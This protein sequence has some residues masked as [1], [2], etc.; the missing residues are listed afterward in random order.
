MRTKAG[1]VVRGLVTM[2]MGGRRTLRQGW[3]ACAAGLGLAIGLWGIPVAG[4]LAQT[5]SVGLAP[6]AAG[7]TGPSSVAGTVSASRAL[8]DPST[9]ESTPAAAELRELSAKLSAALS[10]GDAAGV[11]QLFVEDGELIDE[12]GVMHRGR[13]EIQ[14][15][16]AAFAAKFPGAQ[17]VVEPESLRA[18]GPIMIEDGTRII[19]AADGSVAVIR[20]TAVLV[21]AADGWR[22]ASV[23]DFPDEFPVSPGEQLQ[24]LDWLIG[25]WVNEGVD[26]RVAIKYQWSAD[27]NFILGEYVFSSEGEVVS[28][29]SQRIGWDPRVGKPRSWL[30]DSDGG[31]SEA[32]WTATETG[33]MFR[34]A[35]V[36]PDGS[37]G[38]ATIRME[39]EDGDRF[40]LVGKDRVVGNQP[41]EDFELTV[42]R[43][44]NVRE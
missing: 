2:A 16:V 6:A 38:A 14:E 18:V 29:S 30:F 43:R 42:V 8:Q 7:V 35:A 11:A 37:P 26:G 1:V 41:A 23:R 22:I 36:L 25:D 9:D 15:L 12:G 27:R 40:R 20:F 5:A 33:W 24:A 44:V 10:A 32:E 34:S 28:T 4:G 31:F 21:K 17:V 39:V 13:V 3:P 19:T